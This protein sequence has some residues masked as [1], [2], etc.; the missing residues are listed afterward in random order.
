[1]NPVSGKMPIEEFRKLKDAP[2]GAAIKTIRKYDPCWG[3]KPGEKIKWTV[4][5]TAQMRGEATVE[6]SSQEE[7]EKLADLLP[8]HEFDWE[9]LSDAEIEIDEV[10]PA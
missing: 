2:Y 1:M 5:A 6:A 9:A 4:T 7:A 10:K 3:V 8:D